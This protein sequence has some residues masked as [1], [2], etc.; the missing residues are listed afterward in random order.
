MLQR[1][2]LQQPQ[3]L[4]EAVCRGAVGRAEAGWGV[5]PWG[6]ADSLEKLPEAV[7]AV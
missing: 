2:G 3:I 4:R 6:G 7:Q 1:T 5:S